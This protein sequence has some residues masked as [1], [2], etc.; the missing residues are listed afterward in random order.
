QSM[1]TWK[2]LYKLDRHFSGRWNEVEVLLKHLEWIRV[3]LTAAV[4]CSKNE[5]KKNYETMSHGYPL[6][7]V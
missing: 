1:V 2:R 7:L 5:N 6:R 4:T 3:V